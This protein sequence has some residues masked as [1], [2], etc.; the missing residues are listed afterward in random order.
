M[1]SWKFVMSSHTTEF[2]TRYFFNARSCW[3]DKFIIQASRE[4]SQ[5]TAYQDFML[6]EQWAIS[7][8]NLCCQLLKSL[9][10][11]IMNVIPYMFCLLERH[12]GSLVI[13]DYLCSFIFMFNVKEWLVENFIGCDKVLRVYFNG[14]TFQQ[15]IWRLDENWEWIF[16]VTWRLVTFGYTKEKKI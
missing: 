5:L 2:S 10:H 4:V 12:L 13:K 3:A 14:G 1:Y 6:N 8:D 11:C 7:S 16:K 15:L 9:W